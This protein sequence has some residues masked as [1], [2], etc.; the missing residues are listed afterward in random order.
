MPCTIRKLT[1][2]GLQPVDY[3]AGSLKEAAEHEP[4]DGVYTVAA[5]YDTYGVV[6]LTAHLDRLQ[7]SARREN[8]PLTLTHRQ[9]RAAV[10][11]V[12][13]IAGYGD[14]RF[15]VTVP[16][17]HPNEI[18]ISAEPFGGYPSHY[19]TDGVTVVTAGNIARRNP[20]A[21]DTHWMFDRR[22]IEDK[23]PADVHTAILL[24]ADGNLLEGTG[25][26]FYAVL[27]NTLYTAVDGVLPGTA[28]QIV[29]EVAPEV[30]PLVRRPANIRDLPHMQEA[31]ITSSSRG[32][33][34][35][36]Q[37]DDTRLGDGQPGAYTKAIR[38]AYRAWIDHHAERL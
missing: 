2:S 12:I 36:T 21:K 38:R 37:I 27:D 5:T 17:Q 1:P 34:P 30:L 25:S 33:M 9:I 14:V 6:K 32:V 10:R 22:A 19:Y 28:Q 15:R 35:V 3:T 29:L 7:D 20:A 11:E 16:R 8:I 4:D 13:D 23:L 24:D 31:F 18:I 26:N